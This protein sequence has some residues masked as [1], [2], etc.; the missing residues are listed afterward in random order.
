MRYR[1]LYFL[2]P[3]TEHTARVVDELVQQGV[4]RSEMHV[5]ASPGI[6]T[7]MLPRMDPTTARQVSGQ[8][9]KRY[10]TA[11]LIL[12]FIALTGFAFFLLVGAMVPAVVSG[13]VLVTSFLAGFLFV[14]RV[15]DVHL[16][17]FTEALKHGEILLIVDVP[18]KRVA[19]IE[20]RVHRLHPEA[21]VGG[22]GWGQA[23][24]HG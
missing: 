20:D 11:N 12:F 21:V 14:S 23:V 24:S 18:K 4:A 1:R 9:E 8:T 3:D 7:T 10:W 19:E 6:D 22:V 16:D 17:E 5:V 2:F 15:P 13:I